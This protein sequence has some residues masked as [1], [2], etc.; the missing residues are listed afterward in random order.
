MK[1]VAITL[2]FLAS[3]VVASPLSKRECSSIPSEAS[4]NVLRQVYQ[5]AQQ[6]GASEKVLLATFE[7][8]WVETHCQN[9][10]CGDQDSIGV[11]QQRP[12][13][14]WGSY[15][16]IMDIG[17]ST[18]KFLDVLIPIAARN[19]H[20]SAGTLAQMAQRSEF[21]YRYDQNEAKAYQLLARGRQLAG[22]SSSGGGGSNSGSDCRKTHT[23]VTGHVCSSVASRY[24]ISVAQLIGWN[25]S[26]NGGCTNLKIGQTLCVG[27]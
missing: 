23:V 15:N 10:I 4:D 13:M 19:S 12:S 24:G 6:R 16:Q 21:P 18:G 5:M 26:V 20:L 11:F 22:G 9:L 1:A 7:T 2:T 27:Q 17:Y 25:S 3:L 14:G 8:C